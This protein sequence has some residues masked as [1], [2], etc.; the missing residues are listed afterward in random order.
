MKRRSDFLSLK[1]LFRALRVRIYK[2]CVINRLTLARTAISYKG[3]LRAPPP[4]SNEQDD[5]PTV[6]LTPPHDMF[7]LI[8]IGPRERDNSRGN[9]QDFV[10]VV[11]RRLSPPRIYIGT[12]LGIMCL[13][14]QKLVSSRLVPH[15]NTKPTNST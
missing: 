11:T 14:I 9:P 7:R 12:P 3:T 15:L 4:Y 10:D 13:F 5:L 8:P 6:I 1:K 2:A